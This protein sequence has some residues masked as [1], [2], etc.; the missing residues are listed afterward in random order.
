MRWNHPQWGL[1]SPAEFIPLAEEN[2][3]IIPIGEWVLRT[4]CVQAKA[5]QIK[6]LAPLKVAVNLSARQVVKQNLSKRIVEILTE[7]GL[8]PQFLE[9]EITETLLMQDTETAIK[10]LSELKAIG[11]DISIDDFGIGYSSLN[12]LKKFPFDILKVDRCFVS[13]IASNTENAVITKAIIQMAHDLNLKV[14]AEGVET[15]AELT[16][17]CQQQCNAMQGYL[18]S[19]PIPAAEFEMLLT[20]GKQLRMPKLDF[21]TA[22]LL[23]QTPDNFTTQPLVSFFK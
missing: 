23:R 4:A 2:G 10:T 1:V 19:R 22:L 5:W 6:H 15:E 8:K 16:F 20:A 12:Y 17:L 11:V 3:L 18:F 7:T 14:I 9:L 21:Q 13:N